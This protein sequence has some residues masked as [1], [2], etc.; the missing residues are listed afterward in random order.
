[1]PRKVL[2]VSRLAATGWRPSIDL[3]TGIAG[4]YRWFCEQHDR[5][6]AL[7]GVEPVTTGP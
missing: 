5:R 4:T 7:R 3:D 2:D 6:A 1:M